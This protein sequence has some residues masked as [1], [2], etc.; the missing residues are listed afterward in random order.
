MS[1][2]KTSKPEPLRVD[3]TI[4]QTIGERLMM[5]RGFATQADFASEI[6]INSNTLRAYEKGRSQPSAETLQEICLKYEVSPAWLLLGQG[7]ARAVNTTSAHPIDQSLLEA[8]IEAV[9]EV[10]EDTDRTM[11]PDKKAELIAAIYELYA[12]TEK[13]IDKPRVLRLVKSA[14]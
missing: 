3:H 8:S 9:E 5:L 7:T 11:R 13:S 1:Q 14:L 10:L 2:R 4:G 12:D 6:G